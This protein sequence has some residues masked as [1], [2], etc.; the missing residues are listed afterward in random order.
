MQFHGGHLEELC[1]LRSL[2]QYYG[3]RSI[4]IIARTQV[5]STLILYQGEDQY[6]RLYRSVFFFLP[7]ADWCMCSDDEY[8]AT[9]FALRT[10]GVQMS[11]DPRTASKRLSTLR[12]IHVFLPRQFT[13]RPHRSGKC[14]EDG[15]WSPAAISHSRSAS[16]TR[17]CF[18]S[19]SSLQSQTLWAKMQPFIASQMSTERL[20]WHP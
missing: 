13:S 16:R 20:V 17:R 1:F 5:F 19:R 12:L 2:A 7:M 11:E 15:A 14:V 9:W 18:Q 6:R 4:H 3:S 8:A 10:T